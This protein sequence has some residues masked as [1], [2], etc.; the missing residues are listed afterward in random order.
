MPTGAL[1][2]IFLSDRNA[3]YS[4]LAEAI[5]RVEG[6]GRFRAY[7]AGM[8]PSVTVDPEVLSFLAARHLPIEGLRSRP[9][10]ELEAQ[11]T[12]QF[13]ITLCGAAAAF[14]EQH[15]WRGE[16]LIAHWRLD[17]DDSERESDGSGWA[18]RDAFWT[19]SRRIRIFASLP[20]RKAT[21]RSIEN[22]LFALQAV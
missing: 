9:L 4:V 18:I 13:V 6:N 17:A 11:H 1:N 10:G 12:F 2:V 8:E 16:P 19:L 15:A 3:A 7:G 5:L 14:A 22:R 20:H 21:R